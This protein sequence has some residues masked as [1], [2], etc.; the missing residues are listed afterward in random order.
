MSSKSATTRPRSQFIQKLLTILQ[1]Q[2]G[3]L[4]ND[5][6]DAIQVKN[7]KDFSAQVLP[8]YFRSGNYA[9]FVRQLHFYGFHKVDKS[10]DVFQHVKFKRDNPALARD[11]VR[12]T[13]GVS[14]DCNDKAMRLQVQSLTE[15]LAEVKGQMGT[16]TTQ[17]D[18]LSA[19]LKELYA[20]RI[21]MK[22]QM[23]E[24]R[25]YT[26]R[27][28]RLILERENKL[29]F[30]TKMPV[31]KVNSNNNMQL[32]L[33]Y[34][35]QRPSDSK[36]RK[37]SRDQQGTAFQF[38]YPYKPSD[39]YGTQQP[40]AITRAS[41][42]SDTESMNSTEDDIFFLEDGEDDLDFDLTDLMPPMALTREESIKLANNEMDSN[43][44]T[45]SSS[46]LDQ[47]TKN[48]PMEDFV[49]AGGNV[50]VELEEDNSEA[51]V[52]AHTS[53]NNTCSNMVARPDAKPDSAK[54]E[55]YKSCVQAFILAQ[56]TAA[57]N[58]CNAVTSPAV[59]GAAPA[60]VPAGNNNQCSSGAFSE[61]CCDVI[62]IIAE[63]GKAC[64]GTQMTSRVNT[65]NNSSLSSIT[66]AQMAQLSSV[67]VAALAP[68]MLEC[69]KKKKGCSP[70]ACKSGTC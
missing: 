31:M 53:N 12:R 51:G 47:F 57:Q 45:T 30:P 39:M 23:Q 34:S 63:E 56:L 40:K 10:Q 69:C 1:T 65:S 7:P 15:Q 28:E 42:L 46:A 48:W 43:N 59:A 68:A 41:S 50:Q 3:I 11:I 5:A 67:L 19:L 18:S 27:L 58:T 33:P 14:N 26:Q 52:G 32:A 17:I 16:M 24:Q 49:K 25:S 61:T 64:R 35:P 38:S 4:W 9:S 55:Q 20:D 21:D 22:K 44:S 13:N 36:K 54:F 8:K 6:G 29:S 60:P 66:P 2:D 37:R 70:R 62:D